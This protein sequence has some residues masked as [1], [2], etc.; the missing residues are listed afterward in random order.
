VN[1]VNTLPHIKSWYQR[2]KDQGLIVVGVH[3]PEY[4]FERDTGKVQS[5]IQRHGIDSP[6]AQ[7]NR[8]ATWTAWANRY[9]PAVYWVDRDGH[10]VF[11]HAGE[12]DYEHIE[13][14]IRE[15]L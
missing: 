1:C 4:A 12:G 2:Y 3:T 5:A 9:W 6:V 11:S 8:Y 14:K 15:A 7:D 10:V 13:Q